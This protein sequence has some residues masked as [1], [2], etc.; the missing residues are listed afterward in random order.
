[1]YLLF[2]RLLMKKY[3][4]LI[5]IISI[6]IITFSLFLAKNVFMS[7]AFY[8]NNSDY[9][10]ATNHSIK[11]LVLS[12]VKQRCSLLYDI[13]PSS[14]YSNEFISSDE[15][16]EQKDKSV[17]C[18]IDINFMDNIIKYSENACVVIVKSYYPE[19]CFY[20]ITINKVNGKYLVTSI[21]LDI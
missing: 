17:F 8:F 4:A 14:I 18:I 12:A 3:V 5:T 2:L 19:E 11:T 7:E 16:N 1:M 15:F 13:E 6:F 10:K 9:D 21:L 20:H